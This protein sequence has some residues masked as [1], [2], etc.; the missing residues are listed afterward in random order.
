MPLLP[1][2]ESEAHMTV[3]ESL[4]E[5]SKDLVTQTAGTALDGYAKKLTGAQDNNQTAAAPANKT[6]GDQSSTMKKILV[7]TGIA[8]VVGLVIYLVTRKK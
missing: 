4:V 1:L 8:A 5:N 6:I 7:A 3:W 2:L